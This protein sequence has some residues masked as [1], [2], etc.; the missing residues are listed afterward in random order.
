MEAGIQFLSNLSGGAT[1]ALMVFFLIAG[2]TVFII[3]T[4]IESIGNYVIHLF[5][6]SF[7]TGT[8]GDQEWMA[9][10]TIFYWAWWISWAPFVGTFVA[11]ISRGRTIR[12]FIIGVVAMPT[13]MGFVWF[14]I[15]GSTVAGQRF[16][17]LGAADE[18]DFFVRE[19]PY[20]TFR[21][22]ITL[23]AGIDESAIS[24]EF[25]DGLAEI[26]VAG[27]AAAAGQRRIELKHQP[28]EPTP[29]KLG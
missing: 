2:P 4:A 18:D 17:E 24:A 16:T 25:I 9:A 12:E 28:R 13:G 23:P 15:V 10:W 27:G 7:R 22:S 26:T 3:G 5:P 8:F 11:R 1:I 14:A 29:R 21:R 6:M 19:R 20:G